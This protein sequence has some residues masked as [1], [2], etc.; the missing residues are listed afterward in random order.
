M[1]LAMRAAQENVRGPML[2]VMQPKPKIILGKRNNN[3]KELELLALMYASL[4]AVKMARGY[5]K[6]YHLQKVLDFESSFYF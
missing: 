3:M 2:Y 1:H 6:C 5:K 4:L